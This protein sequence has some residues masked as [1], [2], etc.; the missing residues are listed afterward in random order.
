M[1]KVLVTRWYMS[2]ANSMVVERDAM[3]PFPPFVGLC[4]RLHESAPER[5][6]ELG[7]VHVDRSTWD[8]MKEQFDVE[9]DQRIGSQDDMADEVDECIKAGWRVVPLFRA[10][11]RGG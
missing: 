9:E 10:V 3:L 8:A 7:V 5:E 1:Y 6:N 2:G 11:S 4:L